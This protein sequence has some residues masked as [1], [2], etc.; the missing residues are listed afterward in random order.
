M[1]FCCYFNVGVGRFV[2][3]RENCGLCLVWVIIV[4]VIVVIVFLF[5]CFQFGFG[6][7]GW[8]FVWFQCGDF[9][10]WFQVELVFVDYLFVVFQVFGDLYL[11]VVYFYVVVYGLYFYCVVVLYDIDV[12]VVWVMQYCLGW[13][14][15]VVVDGVQLYVYVDELVWLQVVVGVVEYGV[16]FECVVVGIDQVVDYIEFVVCGQYV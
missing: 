2:G 10:V 3:V 8:G 4:M 16:C 6:W 14:D 13:N 15:Y 5:G 7:C 12:F 9:V 11:V 1:D